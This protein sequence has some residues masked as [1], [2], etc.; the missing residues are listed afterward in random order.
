VFCSIEEC[1]SLYRTK[2]DAFPKF[3]ALREHDL[4]SI[5]QNVSC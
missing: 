3:F 1:L 2:I 5:V 4:V